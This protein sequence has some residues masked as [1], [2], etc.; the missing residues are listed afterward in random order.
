M[1]T[2]CVRLTTLSTGRHVL[3]FMTGPA[4]TMLLTP[5]SAVALACLQR[6]DSVDGARDLFV[7]ST[8][9]KLADAAG[10]FDRHAKALDSLGVLG[11]R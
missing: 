10:T 6:S 11:S 3:A 4:A 1:N 7:T 2:R 9:G 5:T 8:G